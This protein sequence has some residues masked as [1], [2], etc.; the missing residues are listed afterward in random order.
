LSW[1]IPEYADRVMLPE[2]AAP[3]APS[4]DADESPEP[5]QADRVMVAKP[6][7]ATNLVCFMRDLLLMVRV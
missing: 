6:R 1:K 5:P 3:V 7:A 4:V 2:S